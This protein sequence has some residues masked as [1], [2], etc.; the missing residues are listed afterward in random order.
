VRTKFVP[1]AIEGSIR[2]VIVEMADP[3]TFEM[4]TGLGEK[5]T[6]TPRSTEWLLNVTLPLKLPNPV[7]VILS[8]PIPPAG[9]VR[10]VEDA[11]MS[12]SLAVNETDTGKS[13]AVEVAWLESP[14]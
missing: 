3:P 13:G 11:V 5:I 10:D 14:W 9:I 1:A 6:V 2:T 4:V 7:T 8:A 12:K